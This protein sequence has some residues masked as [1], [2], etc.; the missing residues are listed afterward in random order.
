MMYILLMVFATCISVGGFAFT[1]IMLVREQQ[2]ERSTH[3]QSQT[4]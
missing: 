1:Q 3:G 2:H 4:A